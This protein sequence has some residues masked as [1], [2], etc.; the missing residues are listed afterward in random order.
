MYAGKCTDCGLVYRLTCTVPQCGKFYN[1]ETGRPL[2]E[3]YDEHYRSANNPTCKSYEE[4]S[5][6]QHY[7]IKHPGI[8]P[9]F[10]L[11]IVEHAPTTKLR[12][13]KEAR[14]ILTEN[15]ELNSR[16]ELCKLK[17]FLV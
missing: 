15:P 2:Y 7:A 5:I 8:K 11:E 12:K 6:A 13:I 3:R 14:I 17:Q 1:G 10:K 4:K 9:N 16:S